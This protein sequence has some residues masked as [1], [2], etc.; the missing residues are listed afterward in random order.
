MNIILIGMPGCGK[1]MVGTALA[2]QLQREFYDAD[3]VLEEREGKTIPELFAISE[4]AF[5]QAETRTLRY[6]AT[7]E[8]AIIAT[9]G[10]AVT[11]PINMTLLGA[12]GK[13]F[14]LNRELADIIADVDTTTRPLL[15]EG[16]QKMYRLYEERKQLYEHYADYQ[17]GQNGDFGSIVPEIIAILEE[18]KL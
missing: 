8:N 16:K 18:E 7:K 2:Q 5:R 15:Q 4:E 9:G 13:S 1:T 14:Y 3:I 6:L 10:G 12:T 11:R 17:V